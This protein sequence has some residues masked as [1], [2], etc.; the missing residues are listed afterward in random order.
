MLNLARSKRACGDR[1]GGSLGPFGWLLGLVWLSLAAAWAA[2]AAALPSFAQQTGETCLRCHVGAYGPQL[3]QYGRDFKLFGYTAGDG[4][5]TLPPLAITAIASYTQTREDRRAQPHFHTNDNAAFQSAMLAYAGKVAGGVGAFAEVFYDGVRQKF[6]LSRVDVKRTFTDTLA[7]HDVVFGLDANNRPGVQDIWNSSPVF[8]FSAFSSPFAATPS[9][10][11]LID[12]R[13]ASRVAG[14]GAFA[15]WDDTLYTEATAYR[16]LNRGFLNRTGVATAAN[17]DRYTGVLPYWR[18]ALQHEFAETHYVEIGAYG[19]A[20]R[21]FPAGLQSAGEDRFRDVG[22]D[23]T[24]QYIGG[25]RRYLASH[26]TWIRETA[27]LDASHALSGARAS[28]RLDTL[29]ADAIMS[30]DDTWTPAVEVFRTTGDTDPKFFRTPGGSPNSEGYV[31][32]LG[33]APWGKKHSP[34]NWANVKLTARWVGYTR[35]N[36]RTAGASANDTL[37]IGLNAAVAPLGAWVKR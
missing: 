28:D 22:L 23:A 26:V 25:K 17:A 24:Y 9:V 30:F 7:G 5:N 3:K 15:M 33:Y 6:T 2:P 18:L 8:E 21:R 4:Q 34:V 29:R 27:R 13:L 37:F 20:A 36:G 11:P 19:L 31:V 1:P 10:S 35:F 12:G 14:G 32:E 16:P